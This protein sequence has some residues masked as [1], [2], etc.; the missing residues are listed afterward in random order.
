MNGGREN[1]D[2]TRQARGGGEEGGV[3]KRIA[4]G[5]GK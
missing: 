1:R 5:D 3:K 4:S 2:S